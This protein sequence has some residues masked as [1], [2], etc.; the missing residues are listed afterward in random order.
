MSEVLLGAMEID[1]YI[2]DTVANDWSA[3]EILTLVH[4]NVLA[5]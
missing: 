5:S 4:N 2:A 3:I 1:L